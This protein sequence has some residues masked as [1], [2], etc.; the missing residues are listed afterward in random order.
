[1][2]DMRGAAT[3]H[4]NIMLVVVAAVLH[5]FEIEDQIVFLGWSR[6]GRSRVSRAADYRR[7]GAFELDK[8]ADGIFAQFR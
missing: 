2:G 5:L 3:N 4:Q 8:G 1:M 6:R 7:T